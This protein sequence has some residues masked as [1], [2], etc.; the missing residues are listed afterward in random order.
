MCGNGRVLADGS[1][2]YSLLTMSKFNEENIVPVVR[3]LSKF[4]W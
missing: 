3:L 4:L 1:Q 2:M